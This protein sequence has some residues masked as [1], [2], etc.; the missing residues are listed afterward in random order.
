[1]DGEPR[2][3]ARKLVFFAQ[4]VSDTSTVKRAEAFVAEGFDL[5]LFSF[6]RGRY[7]RDF[8]PPWPVVPLGRTADGRYL[9]RAVALL[10]GAGTV[11]RKGHYL[12][13]AD[14]LYARN[15]DQL[16]LA[17]FSR[18]LFRNAAPVIY[19]VL[20][21]Q[22]AFV[23]P[24]VL[25]TL[26]RAVER[27]CLRRIAL[28]VVSSPAFVEHYFRTRQRYVGPW[29]LLENKLPPSVLALPR[30][31]CTG[32]PRNGHVWTVGYFGLIRGDAT[33]QMME[34]VAA[35][36]Q[37]RV[38]F[39]IRG[40]FTTVDRMRFDAMLSRNANIAY[41]GE[42]VSP[43]DLPSIY[44]GVDFAWAIDLEN[45]AHNSRWLLPCRFYEAGFFGVPCLGVRGFES[46]NQIERLG[47]G[48]VLSEPLEESL[49]QFFQTL[50]PE[51]YAV[52]RAR[53]AALPSRHFVSM[54]GELPL[55]AL[56]GWPTPVIKSE[57]PRGELAD[58]G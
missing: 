39:H 35:R 4:D 31:P 13:G 48:W 33:F 56:F 22:P 57:Q 2:R 23:R 20:D 16:V 42:Y 52:K 9:R 11:A 15:I 51:E 24:G 26:L 30:V 37:G 58:A 12:R 40:V 17:L 34:R 55:D 18:V 5:V 10:R 1:M 44:G 36:L 45:Q 53:L 46:G 25:Y 49:V 54:A 19:E 41:L 14:V 50:A 21:V 6:L 29:R 7:H 38:Q 28:L 8:A 43:R 27:L 3:T 32:R 47:T